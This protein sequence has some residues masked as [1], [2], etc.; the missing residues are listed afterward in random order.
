M[1]VDTYT[2]VIRR[3]GLK[4]RRFLENSTKARLAS[5]PSREPEFHTPGPLVG[6]IVHKLCKSLW[7][8]MGGEGRVQRTLN[9]RLKQP[10]RAHMTLM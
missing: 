7:V 10:P 1:S 6:K 4:S 2:R 9:R 3:I 8:V 5:G